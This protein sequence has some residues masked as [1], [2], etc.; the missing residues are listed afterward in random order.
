MAF[1]RERPDC[2][3]QNKP[4]VHHQGVNPSHR[5]GRAGNA[6]FG[7]ENEK[8]AVARIRPSSFVDQLRDGS[9]KVALQNAHSI[10]A[11]PIA[12]FCDAA[13]TI[14]LTSIFASARLGS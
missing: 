4:L 9:G 11:R 8:E 3:L 6:V 7:T 13:I 10:A 5:V 1:G 12:T 2:S 14:P